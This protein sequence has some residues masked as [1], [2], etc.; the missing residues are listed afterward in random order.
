MDNL[1]NNQPTNLNLPN[2]SISYYP[3]FLNTLEAI[4]YYNYFK[5]NIPWQQD[6]IKLF[7]KEY[8]QP[9]LT[10]LYGNNE[11]PY[12]YSSVTMQP[13]TFSPELLK[14]KIALEKIALCNFTSCLLNYY[15]DGSDSNGWHADNEKELGKNP[16]IAS[17]SLGAERYFHLKHNKFKDERKK[18]LLTNGSLL[19]MQGETQHFWKHQIPKT[20]KLIAPRINLTFRIIN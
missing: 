9:R 4:K 18:I 12:S 8:L 6:T 3:N 5:E 19:L 11:K 7:G 17:L 13:L 1:F 20:K 10:A 2:S 16:I 14:I 15:R